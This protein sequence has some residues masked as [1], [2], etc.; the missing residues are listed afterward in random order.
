MSED[1]ARPGPGTRADL[2]WRKWDGSRHWTIEGYYLGSDEW[3]DWFG[4]PPGLHSY[5]ADRDILADGLSVTLLPVSG[6]FA[7]TVNQAPPATYRI[8][9]DLAWDVGWRDGVPGGIDMDLDVV[10][11]IDG[12][13]LWIDDRDEWEEHRVLYGYPREIVVRLEALAL[14]LERRVAAREA[15]FDDAT[16]QRWMD[17]LAALDLGAPPAG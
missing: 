10:W 4:Q 12:R 8:Y 13:G 15:P 9:I 16:A 14:D 11:A 17:R 5:R 1:A 3:G 7:L 2:R 6:D